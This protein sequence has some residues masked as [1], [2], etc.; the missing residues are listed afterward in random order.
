MIYNL[1]NIY[2]F[3]D[4]RKSLLNLILYKISIKYIFP[5]KAV[6]SVFL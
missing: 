6:E 1:K 4:S 5:P 2:I 3:D